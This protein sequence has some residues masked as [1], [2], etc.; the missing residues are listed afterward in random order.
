MRHHTR[1]TQLSIVTCG[2]S[3]AGRAASPPVSPSAR[4]LAGP[5]TGFPF[6]RLDAYKAALELASRVHHARISDPELRDQAGRASKSAFLNLAEGLPDDRPAMRRR[7]FGIAD[8][9]LHETAAAV[10]LAAAVGVL[11]E[12]EATAIL[13]VA[14]RLRAM[15]RGL[16]R[17]GRA[18]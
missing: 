14:A 9:S 17:P 7:H 8:N 6:Q 10:D 15:L 11:G 3:V 1:S 18:G 16:M 12:A 4:S 13:A 5:A 2:G